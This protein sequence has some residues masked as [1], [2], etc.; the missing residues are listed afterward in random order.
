MQRDPSTPDTGPRSTG[1][2][3]RVLIA[4][5]TPADLTLLADIL[6]E[7]GYEVAVATDGA[8]A[9]TLAEAKAPDLIMLDMAMPG[10]DGFQ[11]CRALKANEATRAI[12]VIFLSA[13][14]QVADKAAAFEAGGVDYVTKPLQVDEVMARLETQLKLGRLTRELARRNQELARRNEEVGKLRPL[15]NVVSSSPAEPLPGQVLDGKYRVDARIGAGGFGTVFRGTHLQ[16]GRAVAVKVFRPSSGNDTPLALAR[17]RAEGAAACRVDHPNVVAVL[18]SGISESGVAYLVMELLVGHTLSVELDRKGALSLSRALEIAIPVCRALAEAA[19]KNVVHRDIKPSNVFLHM[20]RGVE[21][22]KVVDFGIAKLMG[23]AP[24]DAP[25]SEVTM[26]GVVGSPMYMSPERLLGWEYDPRSDVYSVGVMLY[27]MLTGR[28]PLESATENVPPGL[29]HMLEDPR[30][31]REHIPA[32]PP[33]LESVVLTA[34]A[35]KPEQRPSAEEL[36]YALG[37]FVGC[38]AGP[39]SY[40]PSNAPPSAPTR[41]G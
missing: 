25:P 30:S 36:A 7:R 37:T 27:E 18:D 13:P 1:R 40:R 38:E 12:P 2:R 35:R 16:L 4:D 29:R 21:V 32:I 34:M 23:E 8:R 3:P 41:G 19:A 20:A 6:L 22:V 24:D 5:D 11:L 33:G 31:L 39:V 17:F 28:L 14:D 26:G 15:V 10:A 9:L